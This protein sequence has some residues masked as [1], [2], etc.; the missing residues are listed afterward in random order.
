MHFHKFAFFFSLHGDNNSMV[1]KKLHF[2]ISFQKFTFSAPQTQLFCKWK[3]KKNTQLSIFFWKQCHVYTPYFIKAWK[4]QP[5]TVYHTFDSMIWDKPALI[6]HT[7]QDEMY[8]NC[9]STFSHRVK[10][11]QNID[12]AREKY[13]PLSLRSCAIWYCVGPG[14]PWKQP[15]WSR[16]WTKS[17]FSE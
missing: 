14:T 10:N 12:K 4:K 7:R 2:E 8:G 3:T 9:E 11:R 1:F 6:L 15:S 13:V 5:E 17:L 16:A